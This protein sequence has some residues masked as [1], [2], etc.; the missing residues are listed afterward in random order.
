MNLE[1][2]SGQPLVSSPG[3]LWSWWRLCRHCMVCRFVGLR[4]HQRPQIWHH[5]KFS[6]FSICGNA[7]L[8]WRH[9]ERD[10]VSNHRRLDCL[11]NRLFRR[12]SKKTSKVRVTGLCEANSPT[13]GEF[14][15]QW[16]GNAENFSILWRHLLRNR[17]VVTV[18][19]CVEVPGSSENRQDYNLRFILC[20]NTF[21]VT[22]FPF[23]YIN[24]GL[25]CIAVNPT[26]M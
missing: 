4:C 21:N 24:V 25:I 8:Q 11:R 18:S 19:E 10:G 13:T 15:E 1:F 23:Q 6:G 3:P 7:S 14:P 20:D 5:K 12:R 9:D 26:I 16:A 17:R 22:T 2:P